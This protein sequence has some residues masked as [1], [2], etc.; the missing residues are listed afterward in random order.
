MGQYYKEPG[1]S[2]RPTPTHRRSGPAVWSH[3]ER[4]AASA[5][6]KTSQEALYPDFTIAFQPIVNLLTGAVMAQEAL[7]RGANA[8]DAA[9]L[10]STIPHQELPT[11]EA[12]CRQ[13]A[14][15]LA[16]KREIT[17]ALSLNITPT[18]I[19]HTRH[20]A[21][22]TLAYAEELGFAP[23]QLMFEL[24]EHA[25]ID[26]IVALRRSLQPVQ[27]RGCLIV[28]D[29]FGA[30]YNGLR[31]LVALRPDVIKIDISLIREIANCKVQRTVVESLTECCSKLDILVIAEG[32]E[33]LEQATIL[34]SLGIGLMQGYL[35]ARPQR[36][37]FPAVSFPREML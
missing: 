3:R 35:F 24:T 34:Q 7:A 18:I 16:R 10:F 32:V 30:G 9:S 11:F 15:Q 8:D 13:R 23:D 4:P 19:D 17:C 28:L 26:D 36:E 25:V 21:S 27:A 2:R 12:L 1:Y 29:D 20:G 14:L 37:R 6:A 33:T 22:A 5:L 31:S